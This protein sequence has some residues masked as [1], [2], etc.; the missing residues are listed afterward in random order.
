MDPATGW[1]QPGV[2]DVEMEDIYREF[3]ADGGRDRQT[4]W[5]ALEQLLHH[6][7]ELFPSGRLVLSGTFVSRQEEAAPVEALDVAIVPDEP[8]A[9]EQWTDA[10]E[11]RFMLCCTLHDVVVASLEGQHFWEMRPF[12]GRID[13]YFAVPDD[14]DRVRMWLGAVTLATG[15]E[16][17]GGRGVLE[18][19]W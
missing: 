14:L 10:E 17:L 6:V 18:V 4:V 16:V 1:L 19:E 5:L 8:S 15:E 3:V 7:K 11:E 13:S 2:L 9:A 12:A